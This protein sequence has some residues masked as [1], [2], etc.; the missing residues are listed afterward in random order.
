MNLKDENLKPKAKPTI[1]S[2]VRK[3]RRALDASGFPQ[4]VKDRAPDELKRRVQKFLDHP[5][6]R[7]R[8]RARR[9]PM[10]R[11][12]KTV[13]HLAHA[14]RH[15]RDHV[16]SNVRTKAKALVRSTQH[17]SFDVLEQRA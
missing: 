15:A 1:R 3:F 12:R 16:D 10:R 17:E 7:G 4:E 6:N 13:K 11:A 2:L 8:K 5:E 14:V 9:E